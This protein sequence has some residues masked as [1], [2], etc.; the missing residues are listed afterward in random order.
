MPT[1][2]MN[3]L[4]HRP[5]HMYKSFRAQTVPDGRASEAALVVVFLENFFFFSACLQLGICGERGKELAMSYRV[6]H[7]TVKISH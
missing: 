1:Q 3:N 7:Q 6:T 2:P 5:C 4:F